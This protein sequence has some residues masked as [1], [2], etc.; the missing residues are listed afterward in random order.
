MKA[1]LDTNI[2]ID[3]EQNNYS[4]KQVLNC[5]NSKLFVLGKLV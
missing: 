3:L 2:Y 4:L 5:F 1:Y